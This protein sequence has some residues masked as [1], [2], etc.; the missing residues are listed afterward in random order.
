MVYSE[1]VDP[2]QPIRWNAR[3][4]GVACLGIPIAAAL[5]LFAKGSGVVPAGLVLIAGIALGRQI[6]KCQWSGD[7]VI[8]LGNYF[9]A[10]SCLLAFLA[11]RHLA[12]GSQAHRDACGWEAAC[13][14]LGACFTIAG[15][16]KHR[17]A[18]WAWTRGSNMGLLIAERSDEGPAWLRSIRWSVVGMPALCTAFAVAS[19]LAEDGGFLFLVPQARWGFA[20]L[21]TGMYAG[22]WLLL[23]YVELDWIALT[24]A[25][26]LLTSGAAA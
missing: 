11:A 8:R 14:V 17:K 9:P 1:G 4:A 5:V 25:L 26:A 24:L 7:K 19:L 12:G 21:A 6:E 10:A 23:G 22:I 16:A 2:R 18:G 20:A 15:F 3:T 13:G